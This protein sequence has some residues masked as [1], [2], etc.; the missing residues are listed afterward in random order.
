MF[1]HSYVEQINLESIPIHSN[2]SAMILHNSVAR[3]CGVR[4]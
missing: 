1:I 4:L 3:F 2:W